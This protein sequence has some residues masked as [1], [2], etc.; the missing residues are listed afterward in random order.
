[1]KRIL[2]FDLDGNFIQEF[3]SMEI[4]SKILGI[5]AGSI[6]AC[7]RG[8]RKQAYGYKWVYKKCL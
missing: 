3:Q 8:E 2:Q 6:S 5:K 4:A 1:M 7:C